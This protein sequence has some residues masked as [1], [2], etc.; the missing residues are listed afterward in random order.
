[1]SHPV[2]CG[3]KVSVK[4]IQGNCNVIIWEK[5]S[6]TYIVYLFK[7]YFKGIFF[8]KQTK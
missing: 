1:M 6:L 3:F 2:T 5:H 8:K 7:I 4:N